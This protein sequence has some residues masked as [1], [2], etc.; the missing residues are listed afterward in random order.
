MKNHI[1]KKYLIQEI[2]SGT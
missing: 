1:Q 2:I